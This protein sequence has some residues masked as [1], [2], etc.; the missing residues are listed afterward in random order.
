MQNFDPDYKLFYMFDIPESWCNYRQIMLSNNFLRFREIRPLFYQKDLS[1]LEQFSVI[2]NVHADGELGT[3]I[4]HNDWIEDP[5]INTDDFDIFFTI[6]DYN[7]NK[8]ERKLTKDI[9]F[10]DELER[11]RND[12]FSNYDWFQNKDNIKY[13]EL[14]TKWTIVN[15][16]DKPIALMSEKDSW[17]LP[18]QIRNTNDL[19]VSKFTKF[20]VK[21]LEEGLDYLSI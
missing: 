16:D 17:L 20:R 7:K 12:K 3:Y 14:K 11:F 18:N 5:F 10:F 9:N 13:L 6:S 4:V 1:K 21:S 15:Y 2:V 19:D 8:K